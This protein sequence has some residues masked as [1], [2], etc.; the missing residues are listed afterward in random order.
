LLGEDETRS[1]AKVGSRGENTTREVTLSYTTREVT[2]SVA[3][4][5]YDATSSGVG[6]DATQEVT[7]SGATFG[8][9]TTTREVTPLG[10]GGDKAA[11]SLGREGGKV[12]SAGRSG[13]GNFG[14]SIGPDSRVGSVLIETPVD[15]S[16][17]W[18]QIGRSLVHKETLGNAITFGIRRIWRLGHVDFHA[19]GQRPS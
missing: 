14:V 19:S 16:L 5:G 9:D 6:Y 10:R 17:G 8:H 3:T 13:G 11:V 18:K 4:V 1:G 15:V 2:S 12:R 7:L